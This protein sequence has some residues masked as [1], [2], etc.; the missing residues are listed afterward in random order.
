MEAK[1]KILSAKDLD[2]IAELA[3]HLNPHMSIDEVKKVHQAV[4]DYDSYTCFGLVENEKIIGV[5]GLWKSIKTYSG[6]QYEI[7][8]LVVDPSR[9]SEG[10]GHHFLSL[11][12]KWAK[13]KGAQTL[14]LNTYTENKA[15]HKFYHR[16]GFIILGFHFQKKIL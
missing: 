3:R 2:A 6:L 16:E 15:S 9:Q 1:L 7:D 13:E 8:H 14:E 5:C 12:E 11:M 4:F 10:L